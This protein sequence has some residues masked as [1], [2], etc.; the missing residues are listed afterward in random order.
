MTIAT[1]TDRP[2]SSSSSNSDDS[3]SSSPCERR[4]S[5]ESWPE[6]YDF[7]SELDDDDYFGDDEESSLK[8]DRR[9]DEESGDDDFARFLDAAV[10]G[11]SASSQLDFVA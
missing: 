1:M 8:N 11:G 3:T 7:A 5:W 2:N 6:E 9:R 4:A 10:D